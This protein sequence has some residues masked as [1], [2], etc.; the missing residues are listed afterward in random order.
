MVEKKKKKNHWEFVFLGANIDA[1]EVAGRFGVSAS[2]AVR[3]ENDCVGS[4]LNFQV[5]RQMASGIKRKCCF[6]S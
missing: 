2:R 5:M 3:F 1:I 6:H 4:D